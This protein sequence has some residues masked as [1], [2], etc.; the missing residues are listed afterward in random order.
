MARHVGRSRGCKSCLKRRIKVVSLWG[1]ECSK[2]HATDSLQCDEKLPE[3]SQC[4]V[5]G[6]KC[7]GVTVG[8]VFVTMNPKAKKTER[9]RAG[10]DSSSKKTT[11]ASSD[12]SKDPG[13]D[14]SRTS[15]TPIS[16]GGSLS[17]PGGIIGAQFLLPSSYQP[18]KTAPFEQLFLDHFI[19]AFDHQKILNNP[20]GSWYSHLPKLY[21]TSPYP[22]CQAATRAS[23]MVYYGA[24]TSNVPIQTEAFRWY[25]KALEYQREL[26]EK[27]K[28]DSLEH[29]PLPE[30]LVAIV[31]LTLFELICSTTP[32]GWIDHIAAG[33]TMI[34]IRKPENCQTGLAHLMFRTMRPTIVSIKPIW[35]YAT[36]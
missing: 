5:R 21:S 13:S 22:L 29:M 32:T 33:A 12:D 26:L 28:P 3:C 9:V 10:Q 17:Q 4:V 35:S 36:M 34:R 2:V 19:S 24:M 30:D 25:S 6:N 14:D 31:L 7:P 18:S 27:T 23:M 15:A 11:N 8:A 16:S 1:R 20:T